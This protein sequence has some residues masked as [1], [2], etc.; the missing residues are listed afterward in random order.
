MCLEFHFEHHNNLERGDTMKR[1]ICLLLAVCSVLFGAV[2]ASAQ[3]APQPPRVLWIYREDVKPARGAAH[4]RV[5]QGL[6]QHWAKANVQPFLAIEAISG[7]ATDVMFLSGYDSF[8]AM[9]KDY[10]LFGKNAN[11]AEYDALER[12]EAGL[13]NSVRSTVAMLRPD[14]SYHLDKFVSVL[15]QSRYFSIETFRVRLGKDGDFEAGSKAFQAAFEKMKRD[16]PYAMYQVAMGGP[17]GTYM[18]F[19]PM[20]SMKELD[21]SFASMGG[22][23]QAMGEENFKN[24]MKSAG[25]VFVTMESNVYAFN[26]YMSHVPKDVAAADPKFWTPKPMVKKAAPKKKDETKPATVGKT[27]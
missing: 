21:D 4:Q 26:P 24:M 12:E 13:V 7:N 8:A 27:Q 3:T 11:G 18:L 25:D 6:A 19:E 23:V 20:K 1:R 15:S 2:C 14:L 5:E 10:A 9:E 17:E 22:L 16:Q